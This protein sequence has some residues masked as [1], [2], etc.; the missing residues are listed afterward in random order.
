MLNAFEKRAARLSTVSEMKKRSVEIIFLG[1]LEK[2]EKY[3][4]VNWDIIIE[5]IHK[6]CI[7]K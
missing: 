4:P 1:K 7:E 2:F 6:H 3:F 5:Y